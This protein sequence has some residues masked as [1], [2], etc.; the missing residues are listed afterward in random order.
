VFDLICAD[1]DAA[2]EHAR[3]LAYDY[4]VELWRDKEL[5]AH[6]Q[7]YS[8]PRRPQLATSKGDISL[9]GGRASG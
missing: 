8:R 6:L 3:R 1:D 4:A 9:A 2:K 7:D 5:L